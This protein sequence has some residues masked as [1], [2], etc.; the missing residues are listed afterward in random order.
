M[1][2]TARERYRSEL[3]KLDATCDLYKERSVPSVDWASW[4]YVEYPDIYNFLIENPSLYTGESLK[5]YNSLDAYNYYVNGWV[6][7]VTVFK[8][9]ASIDAYVILGEVRHSQRVSV[10]PLKPWVA[11][12]K[13]GAVLLG[14]YTCMAGLGESYSHIAALLFAIEAPTLSFKRKHPVPLCHAR[15][16]PLHFKMWSMHSSWT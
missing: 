7:N 13:D 12:R 1:D 8:V 15:G 16:C 11:I 2:D 6:R 14:H 9:P 5:A 3:G 10:T 4:P